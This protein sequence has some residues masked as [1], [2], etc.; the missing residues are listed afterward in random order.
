[1]TQANDTKMVL[2]V[3][4]KVK[5][6]FVYKLC[7]DIIFLNHK[8]SHDIKNRMGN[9]NVQQLVYRNYKKIFHLPNTV[10]QGCLATLISFYCYKKHF[11]LF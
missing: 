2:D 11:F 10:F 7:K 6:P 9:I 1:M 3:M 8:M 5:G 4:H